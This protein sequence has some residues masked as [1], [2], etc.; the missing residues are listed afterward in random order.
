M[1]CVSGQGDMGDVFYAA[2]GAPDPPPSRPTFQGCGLAGKMKVDRSQVI[3]FLPSR[4]SVKHLAFIGYL[5]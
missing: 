2:P 1:D 5:L 4:K 3:P